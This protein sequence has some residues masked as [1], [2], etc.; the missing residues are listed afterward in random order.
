MELIHGTVS[1][2]TEWSQS[3]WKKGA[4]MEGYGCPPE[5]PEAEAQTGEHNTG[6][7]EKAVARTQLMH[8]LQTLL[9]KVLK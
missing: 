1:L 8:L 5:P 4:R 3:S 6:R 9:G 2:G 7:G